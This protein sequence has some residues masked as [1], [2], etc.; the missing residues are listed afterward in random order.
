MS[1]VLEKLAVLVH[2]VYA[3][4]NFLKVSQSELLF[5][6]IQDSLQVVF[7]ERSFVSAEL[8]DYAAKVGGLRDFLE[9]CLFFKFGLLSVET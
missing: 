4:E 3:R 8:A 6:E 5:F 1:L 7:G 2:V 9:N